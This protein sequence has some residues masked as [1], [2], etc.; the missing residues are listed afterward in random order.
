M[1]EKAEEHF[2]NIYTKLLLFELMENSLDYI[3]MCCERET[4]VL[5]M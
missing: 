4:A 2:C 5:Y 1:G 3:L